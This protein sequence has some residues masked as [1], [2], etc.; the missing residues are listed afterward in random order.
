MAE[1]FKR[2][3]STDS[4]AF[5]RDLEDFGYVYIFLMDTFIPITG[6][7]QLFE[8]DDSTDTQ[9]DWVW[10]GIGLPTEELL[11]ETQM[12]FGRSSNRWRQK[13]RGGL[14]EGRREG[15]RRVHQQGPRRSG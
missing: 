12:G 5:S 8:R 1:L 10:G 4:G 2:D 3:D 14:H 7:E 13:W 6:D 11:S 9:D 15:D